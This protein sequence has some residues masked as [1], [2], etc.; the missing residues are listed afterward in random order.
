MIDRAWLITLLLIALAPAAAGQAQTTG[1]GYEPPEYHDGQVHREQSAQRFGRFTV[2]RLVEDC[3]AAPMLD[4]GCWL[5]KEARLEWRDSSG[6]IG[7][8]FID[9]GASVR[10]RGEGAS[11]DG[12]TVCLMPDVLVGY[13][14]KPSTPQNWSRLQPFI[15]RQLGGCTAIA[16]ADLRRAMA[17]AAAADVDYVTAA[18]AWKG[19]S[20]AL[21]GAGGRRCVAERMAKP[22]T[23][24]PRF[25]CTR[26]SAP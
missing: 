15:A 25:E 26:Y 4:G 6:A 14:S 2:L 10:F 16:P 18:N 17:D 13:D 3:R 12:K 19:V 5:N 22:R 21:F 8:A 9:N 7:F 1:G 23:M 11:G 20:V 24:P